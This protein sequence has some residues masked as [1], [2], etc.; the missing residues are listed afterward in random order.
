MGC[1]RFA[2]NDPV[3]GTNHTQRTPRN[4]FHG[5]GSRGIRAQR[6]HVLA[7]SSS[8]RLENG[9]LP[10]EITR[11]GDQPVLGDETMGTE[12]TVMCEVCSREQRAKQHQWQPPGHLRRT[13]GFGTQHGRDL[14][15]AGDLRMTLP[16]NT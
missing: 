9:H 6:C 8:H 7:Q 10:I 12:H 14:G 5:I 13:V 2:Q 1:Q 11:S 15:Y 16:P 4:L 3:T